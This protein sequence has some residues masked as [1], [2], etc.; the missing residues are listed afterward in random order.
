MR[1]ER[2]KG[3]PRKP[4]KIRRCEFGQYDMDSDRAYADLALLGLLMEDG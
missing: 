2:L 1:I 3:N 4:G